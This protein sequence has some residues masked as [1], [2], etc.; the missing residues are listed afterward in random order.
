VHELRDLPDIL[1]SD[2]AFVQVVPQDLLDEARV[3]GRLLDAEDAA[4]G[5]DRGE[6]VVG[7]R[8]EGYVGLRGEEGGRVGGLA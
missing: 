5:H 2:H 4:F 7:G 6:G 1:G 3:E 8:E